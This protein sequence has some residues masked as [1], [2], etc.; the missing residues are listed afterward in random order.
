MDVQTTLGIEPTA[1][2]PHPPP[3]EKK[4]PFIL[5]TLGIALGLFLSL[6][7]AWVWSYGIVDADDCGLLRIFD[8]ARYAYPS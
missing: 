6:F 2:P 8:G 4:S 7:R 3:L 5:G 1:Q